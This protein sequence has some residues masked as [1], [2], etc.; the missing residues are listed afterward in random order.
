MKVK[1][2]TGNGK[3]PTY[4]AHAKAIDQKINE[5]LSLRHINDPD[6]DDPSDVSDHESPSRTTKVQTAVARSGRSDV[7]EPRRTRAHQTAELVGKIATALDPDTQRARDE[8]R[9]NR[10]LQQTHFLSLTH[11]LRDSQQLV[12]SLQTEIN[13]IRDRL[14]KVERIRDR[15]D[16]EL[17]FERRMAGT[18]MSAA[19]RPSGSHKYYSDIQ[20]VRGKVRSTV[21]YPEGGSCT[22]WITDGSSASDFDDK[23]NKIPTSFSSSNWSPHKASTDITDH[24]IAEP[25][26]SHTSALG[27]QMSW[28]I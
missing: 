10:S 14:H 15:L 26:S 12:R 11:Q 23:E 22:T 3:R 1:K 9:A 19:G 20:R 21:R 2:P 4:I 7:P 25:S 13:Q 5:K 27:P 17:N 24:S 28:E 18:P 8:E 6:R 16:M